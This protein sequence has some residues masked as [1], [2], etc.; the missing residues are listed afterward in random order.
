VENKFTL[1]FADY[2]LCHHF[3]NYLV[4]NRLPAIQGIQ[5]L[6]MAIEKIR[7]F[8]SHLTPIHADLCQLS[9]IA[10]MFN[11]AI[12][13]LDVDVTAIAS[14]DVRH[15]GGGFL[16]VGSDIFLRPQDS[17][18][19]AKYFLLY[20]YYGGMIYTAVKNYERALYFFEVS[21]STPAFAMSHIMLE[22]YKKYI[23][24][25]LILNGKIVPIPKYSSQVITRFMKPLSHAYHETANAYLTGS[26]DEVRSVINKYRDTFNRD[27]NMG[28]VKQVRANFTIFSVLH[29]HS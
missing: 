23:M 10:K 8:D 18:Q 19:D 4:K 21:I 13:F 15:R 1:L 14:T 24:V 29:S 22:S 12:G 11:T 2:E 3:V 5:I 28:L 9:L 6:S 17:N 7:L 16:K 20:Y 25:S 26:S 27:T